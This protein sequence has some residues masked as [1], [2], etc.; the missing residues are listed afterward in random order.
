MEI[1]VVFLTVVFAAAYLF[2][3]ASS[4][5]KTAETGCSWGGC[6]GCSKTCTFHSENIHAPKDHAPAG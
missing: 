3:R 2:C 1:I 4:V 6:T 5:F